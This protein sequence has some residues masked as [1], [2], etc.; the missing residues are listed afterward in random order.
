MAAPDPA[1]RGPGKFPRA[2]T[3]RSDAQARGHRAGAPDA[4]CRNVHGSA[5][6]VRRGN[7]PLSRERADNISALLY[8]KPKLPAGRIERAAIPAPDGPWAVLGRRVLVGTVHPLPAEKKAVLI[9][10][11]LLH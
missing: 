3:A 1:G 5:P 11:F 10:V 7:G 4:A 6:P 8:P 9:R 2:S